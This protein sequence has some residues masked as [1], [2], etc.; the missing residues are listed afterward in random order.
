MDI[1]IVIPTYN[2]SE[3]LPILI[4]KI[5][6]VLDNSKLHGRIIVV[7]DDSPDETWKTALEL[8]NTHENLEVLR[9]QDKRGLSS[10]VL[11]GF[12]MSQS[13]VL[14]VMDAD[15]SHPPEKIPELV[16]P[17][18]KGD[19]DITIGSRYID[20]GGIGGW[21]IGRKIYS[22]IATLLVLGLTDV[23]DPMSGFFVLRR[24]VIENKDLNPL[25]FKIGL[26]ILVRGEYENVIEVP[27]LFGDRVH[28]DSKL[29]G[30]V[31]LDY[32]IHLSNLYIYKYILRK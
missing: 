15:L 6:E 25:G 27:I 8:K 31:V 13:P 22:K 10:A 2:E 18:I 7:D 30:G 14:G 17:I 28:G 4:E 23:I 1:T 11:E 9:R 16:D 5:T 29:G 21:S 32:L 24:D 20:E 12:A 19:A 26:E 3:N